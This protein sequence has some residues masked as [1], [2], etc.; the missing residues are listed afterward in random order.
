[1]KTKYEND[2]IIGNKEILATYSKTGELLR[3]YYPSKDNR[4]WID[5][6]ETGV[7]VNDS[8]M[9][10]T[11][12]DINNIYK[13][14]YIEQTN[15][16][17][18]QIL[19]TYF[20]LKI[21]QIDCIPIHH[22]V[23]LKRY[24]FENQNTI[25]LEVNFLI[26]SKLHAGENNFVSGY[27]DKNGLIQYS[28]DCTLGILAKGK[29]KQSHQL[30]NVENNIH[31]G[32][33]ADKDYIGMSEESAVSYSLGVLKPGEKK[34]FELGI[35]AKENLEKE[36]VLNFDKEKKEIEKI[37]FSKEIASTKSYWRKYLKNHDSIP[38]KEEDRVADKI[39]RIY[40]RS[41]L[42]FPLLQNTKTG[43]IIAAPEI[44][45]QRNKCGR[46]AY[47][48]TR[49]A[50]FITKA[51]DILGMEKE[52][53]KFYKTFCKITQLEN[54]MWEQRYYTDGKLAP[55]WGYQIDETASVVYGVYEH[56]QVTKDLRFLKDTL[57]MCE[58]ATKFLK[59]YI[60]DLFSENPKMQVTY[61][62]WEMYEGITMYSLSSIFAS[63]QSMIA[64]YNALY[65]TY[66]EKYRVKQ[67]IIRREKEELEELLKQI[68]KY[69][70][71]HFYDIQKNSF[72]RNEQDKKMDISILGSVEPFSVFKPKEKKIKNTVEKINLTLRTYT[73]GYKRFE[74][75]NYMG[76][77]PWVI[78]NLW[79]ALYYLKNGENTK[80]R[81]TVSYVLRTVN[82]NDLLP[83]QMNNDTK[84]RWV[85]GLGWSHAMFIIVLEKLNKLG[86]V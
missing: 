50:V 38:L 25:D 85:I 29:E 84:Q 22:N 16:L 17:K 19:N 57:K 47:C 72:V 40:E 1:M 51:L 12:Q 52:V 13:Q 2:A 56:Y 83:E 78:S 33:I 44:D 37:D 36:Q 10:Y 30:N 24:E 9:I 76:G 41:I 49:D 3:F 77:N 70:E 26:H 31:T 27:A 43:G 80:A 18:T 5:S 65:D 15:I 81:E 48:W 11:H 59:K 14:N 82:E 39:R 64:I 71:E 75:D 8:A 55:C 53:E 63:F 54:G 46:Y 35:F 20:H 74:E 4:Q 67:E 34:I 68:K 28:H 45:E 21:T 60:T 79:M 6:F 69:I 7:K 62:L 73:G 32:V 61:D 66:E 23:L 86:L 58:K 42:L